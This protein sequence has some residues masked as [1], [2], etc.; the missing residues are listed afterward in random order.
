MIQVSCLNIIKKFHNSLTA[1]CTI[2]IQPDLDP[3]TPFQVVLRAHSVFQL[4]VDRDQPIK[5]DTKNTSLHRT[6]IPFGVQPGGRIV[7][8]PESQHYSSGTSASM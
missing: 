1:D 6:L 2:T 8:S 4:Q 7:V 5:R 3:H